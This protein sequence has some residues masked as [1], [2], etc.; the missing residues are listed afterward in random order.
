MKCTINIEEKEL[1][2]EIN[3]RPTLYFQETQQQFP[4]KEEILAIEWFVC[5][6]DSY[7]RVGLKEPKNAAD[8]LKKLLERNKNNPV[9]KTIKSNSSK[10]NPINVKIKKINWEQLDFLTDICYQKY[11]K[12]I[13]LIIDKDKI[14]LKNAIIKSISTKFDVSGSTFSD[15]IDVQFVIEYSDAIIV[16]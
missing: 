15:E 12:D 3:E 4:T 7:D 16:E 1:L 14:L 5:D 6:S 11:Q 8:I 10:W 2:A 13:S 9:L